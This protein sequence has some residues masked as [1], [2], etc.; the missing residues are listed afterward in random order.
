[1]VAQGSRFGICLSEMVLVL[2]GGLAETRQW[3]AGSHVNLQAW[4]RSAMEKRPK[5]GF[6]SPGGAG[7][8]RVADLANPARV[9][10]H[11]AA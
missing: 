7:P 4:L 10:F 5:A 11:A 8:E 2:A 6:A 3:P 1:M 9:R